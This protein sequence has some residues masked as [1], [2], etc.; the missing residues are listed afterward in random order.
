MRSTSWGRTDQAQMSRSCAARWLP[1]TGLRDGSR[2]ARIAVSG[3][4]AWEAVDPATGET[5]L[6]T[7]FT[8]TG[9][10][11]THL[12]FFDQFAPSHQI[13]SADSA[14]LLFAGVIEEG[15]DPQVW[16]VDAIGNEAPRAVAEGRLAFWVPSPEE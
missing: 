10:F 16:I 14:K 12:Q 13:W 11:L 7:G 6:L 15:A 1:S 8:P 4:A 5:R 2:I 3:P 9:D